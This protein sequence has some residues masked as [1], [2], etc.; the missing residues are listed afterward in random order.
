MNYIV[1]F[2]KQMLLLI[3][4]HIIFVVTLIESSVL[5]QN[6]KPCVIMLLYKCMSVLPFSCDII[7]EGLVLLLI[8][9]PHVMMHMKSNQ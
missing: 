7:Y 9:M 3:E 4:L 1:S 6:I 2:V 5:Q 8:N